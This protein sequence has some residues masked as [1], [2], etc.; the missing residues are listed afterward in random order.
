MSSTFS[1]DGIISGLKTADIISQ[2]MAVERQPVVALQNKQSSLQKQLD[3]LK[4]LATRLTSL[5]AT[6]TQLTLASTF[7]GK[8]VS[9]D[10]PSGAA[11]VLTAV[12]SGDASV[13]SFAVTVKQLATATSA[14]SATAIGQP[15]DEAAPLSQAGFG[16]TPTTGVFTINGAQITIDASTTLNS[17]PNSVVALINGAGVGVTAS[18]ESNRLVL[19]S[20]APMQLGSGADTSNFLTAAKVLAAPQALVGGTY[21]LTSMGNLGVAKTTAALA[22][23]R[24]A[25]SL[26]A[27]TGSFKINGV[28]IA[29][30]S[31]SDSLGNVISRIN[32]SAAGVSA[33]YDAQADRL[34]LTSKATGSVG[35]ALQDVGGDFL[36]AMGVAGPAAQ[37]LGQNAR[38]SIDGV[39]GGADLYS[40]SNTVS[41][42]VT[43][44]TLTLKSVSATPVTV[45]VA[46]DAAPVVETVKA[47]VDQYNSTIGVIQDQTAY[48]SASK[49]G[50]MF[51]GD[52]TVQGLEP[53]LRTLLFNTVVGA[54]GGLSNLSA[55]GITSG[56]IG[57]AP[58]T[59]SRLTLDEA[60]LTSAVESNPAVV[61]RLFASPTPTV[62]LS[63]GGTGSIASVTSAPGST[64][65]PGT[66]TITS[67][68]SGNIS[69]VF[70]PP[71][72]TP[73]APTT[74]TI[75][76]GGTNSSLI[77]GLTLHARDP[78]QAGTDVIRVSP[79]DGVATRL[80]AYLDSLVGAG[81]TLTSRNTSEGREIDRLG[82]QIAY[83]QDLLSLKQDQLVRKYTAL[84]AML[85]QYQIQ[86]QQLA[87]SI[88]SMMGTT[89]A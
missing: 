74:G 31:Q 15:V 33:T 70:T 62:A 10:T 66:Y 61:A 73:G 32:S 52:S 12:A 58:G 65:L 54:S 24:L 26:S 68:A 9:T 36:A 7:S 60:K 76:A 23:A 89:T 47:F 63:A 57:S 11:T 77:A 59:T 72:G 22:S 79:A 75:A 64:P 86:S 28:E 53:R 3:A 17:G 1:I 84:E 56:A 39:N 34:V 4:D 83:K 20:A 13:G 69:V 51:L 18:V 37:T 78:L 50:G 46:Q 19:R 49:T 43:G 30:D 27:A 6:L 44:V 21:E 45:T 29:W 16:T 14:A 40:V 2:L 87:A 55:I 5:K 85:A 88:A 71:G 48:N 25:T 81:G 82:R 67:D 42:V 8:K 41:G 38:Y 35:I 80:G